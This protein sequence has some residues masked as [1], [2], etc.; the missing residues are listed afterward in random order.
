MNIS[1]DYSK[2]Y[3]IIKPDPE[4][5]NNLM[6]FGFEIG[7]GWMPLLIEMLD[8][9][10]MIVNNNPEYADVEIVQVKEKY[11]SMIV[12]LNYYYKEIEDLINEYEEKSCYICEECGQAGEI[13]NIN[14]WY[15][16]L[17]DKHYAEYSKK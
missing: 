9:I 5:K 7:E 13:R 6:A 12:Y 11:G 17:C 3:T 2:K 8:K 10:Q 4:L 14:N 1:N 15:T 16:A